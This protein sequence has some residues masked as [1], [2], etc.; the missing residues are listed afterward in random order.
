MHPAPFPVGSLLRRALAAAAIAALPACSPEISAFGAREPHGAAKA[1]TFFGA[2]AARFGVAYRDARFEAIRPRMVRHALSPSRLYT[3]TSIWTSIAPEVRTVAVAGSLVGDRYVLAARPNVAPPASPGDSRHLMRLRRISQDVHRWDSTDELAVGRVSP[4]AAFA[5]IEGLIRGAER[6]AA[7]IQQE[8]RATFPRTTA[9]L[10]R[11]FV[12]DTLRTTPDDDGS[13]R[14]ALVAHLDGA[15]MRPYAPRYADYID[16]YLKPLRIDIALVDGRGTTWGTVTFA[17]NSLRLH[18]RVRDGA[19]LPLL[20]GAPVPRPDTLRLRASFFAK[21]LI[22]N[23]GA[24][25][26]VADVVPIREP[27]VRG[28]SLRFTRE[29]EWQ[30]PLSVSR[31]IRASLRRPFADEGIRL[32]YVARETPN[33]QTVLA[34]NIGIV[35]QEGAIVRWI[36]GLGNTAMSDLS[37]LAEQEKDRYVGDVFR[38]LASDSRAFLA[39]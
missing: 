29:P 31:L 13:T 20:G 19:L 7:Q 8:Y 12:L 23:V 24:R 35:V 17:R 36:G 33:G 39:R 5:L 15:R 34:R 14:V 3:D 4:E 2:L 18:V 32:E 21:V 16:K 37:I 26:I 9:T 1:E 6:P 22:F 30:F 25:E 11:L 28:W 27:G 38:A 10:S